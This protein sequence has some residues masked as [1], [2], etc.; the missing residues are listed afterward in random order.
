M[1][2]LPLSH[3]RCR[4]SLQALPPVRR[5]L[6][7]YATPT[8]RKKEP[9]DYASGGSR[10]LYAIELWVLGALGGPVPPLG[11]V[12]IDH[13]P[14]GPYV[15]GT[16]VLV[17]QVVGVL[18]HVEPYDG[19]LAL[20]QGRVLVGRLLDRERAI[21]RGYK[22]HPAGPE[23]APWCPHSCPLLLEVVEGTERRVY[24]RGQLSGRFAPALARWS[25]DL[26]EHRMVGVAASV[27]ADGPS[28]VLWHG[29]YVGQKLLDRARVG[30]GM[31]L[32]G[33]VEVG[34]VGIVVFFVVE[35]HGLFVYGGLQG[36]VGV[37]QLW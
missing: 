33:G 36:V 27:V 21:G 30:F 6:C 20:H 23:D 4:T 14:P 22:P 19:R 9:P 13:F 5:R 17:L 7:R 16:P 8:W 25:H 31:L 26:P 28:Y 3:T 11:L 1:R 2:F 24:G 35:V 10:T 34:D 18:P 29:I 12:P 15:L 37:G 32:E